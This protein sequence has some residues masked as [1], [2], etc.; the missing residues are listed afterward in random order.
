MHFHGPLYIQ[1]PANKSHHDEGDIL[2]P[3]FVSSPLGASTVINP[4]LTSSFRSSPR[5][6]MDHQCQPNSQILAGSQLTSLI[7][8]VRRNNNNRHR[9]NSHRN[10]TCNWS[11]VRR[12]RLAS[13]CTGPR[14]RSRCDIRYDLGVQ[15][16]Y[17]DSGRWLRGRRRYL[18][19]VGRSGRLYGGLGCG[20]ERR[21]LFEMCCGGFRRLLRSSRGNGRLR[22]V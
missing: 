19:W 6:T 10:L 4:G 15:C 17:W 9:H 18:G 21:G 3:S 5:T 20:C 7:Q 11:V 14:P 22:G 2:L 13:I 16:R 12:Q 1:I 8:N